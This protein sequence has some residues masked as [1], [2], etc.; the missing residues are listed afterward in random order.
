MSL[1]LLVPPPLVLVCIACTP[2]A[3]D[4][5]APTAIPDPTPVE[6]VG[7]GALLRPEALGDEP[8]WCW[9][10][11]RDGPS[12]GAVA[13]IGLESGQWVEVLGTGP[14]GQDD[15]DA[16]VHRDGFLLVGQG[17]ITR[18]DLVTGEVEQ[19]HLPDGLSLRAIASWDDALL[20][21]LLGGVAVA[22]DVPDLVAGNT[23][24][25]M[26]PFPEVIDFAE[27]SGGVL[28][29]R[30]RVASGVWPL[31]PVGG[32]TGPRVTLD[33]P[34]GPLQGLSV[35]G[36]RIVTLQLGMAS[37][38]VHDLDGALVTSHAIPLPDPWVVRGLWCDSETPSQEAP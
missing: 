31:D 19:H 7:T 5:H 33:S 27:A 30:P 24:F 18:V 16:T 36:D 15:G 20:A 12:A 10:L 22:E 6:P 9:V 13:A 8:V 34:V 3:D 37:L 2:P 29:A 1:R 21:P 28:Y 35:A 17:T 25:P 14:L 11:R 4:V 23:A 26:W 38:Y 32:V